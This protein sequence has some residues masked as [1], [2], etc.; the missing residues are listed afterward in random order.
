MASKGF[1]KCSSGKSFE[2]KS[3]GVTDL[4]DLAVGSLMCGES[5]AGGNMVTAKVTSEQ[6]AAPG[7][8]S[9][10]TSTNI[11]GQDL[12]A[13]HVYDPAATPQTNDRKEIH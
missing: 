4:S 10:Q 2:E 3:N 12:N 6:L 7:T 5:M 1:T 9:E 13:N 11:L 8:P